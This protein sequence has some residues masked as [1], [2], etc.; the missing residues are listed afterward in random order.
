MRYTVGKKWIVNAL[1]TKPL[2]Q[3]I[4]W[5]SVNAD[6]LVENCVKFLGLK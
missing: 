3:S 4:H 1:L 6:K 5:Q 2:G